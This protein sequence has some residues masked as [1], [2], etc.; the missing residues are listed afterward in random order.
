MLTVLSMEHARAAPLLAAELEPPA[1]G[2]RA[3]PNG[4]DVDT[5]SGGCGARAARRTSASAES[6][7]VAAFCAKLDA[8]H[9]TKRLDLAI[10]AVRARARA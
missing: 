4:V 6:A 9:L 1:L 10:E 8:A 3:R 5:F 7:I 2:L